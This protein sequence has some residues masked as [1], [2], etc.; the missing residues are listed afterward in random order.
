MVHKFSNSKIHAISAAVPKNILTTET[1]KSKFQSADVERISNT[2][3][4][5]SFRRLP[6]NLSFLD[7]A[8][9]ACD[10]IFLNSNVAKNQ[11]QCMI[12]VTNTPDYGIPQVGLR[13]HNH[14]QLDSSVPCFDLNMGCS[15]FIFGLFQAQMMI[16]AGIY[17][18]ILLVVGETQSKNIDPNDRSTQLIFGDAATAI[19]VSKNENTNSFFNL[20]NSGVGFDSIILPNSGT[21]K[22]S[23]NSFLKINGGNLT[24]F[25]L[26]EAPSA[27][28]EL[29]KFAQMPI[30][31]INHFVLHQMNKLIIDRIISKLS[32]D[33]KK[34]IFNSEKI[35]N[36]G[37]ASIPLALCNEF[38]I[39]GKGSH[40]NQDLE[41]VLL[42]GFGA[43]LSWG[44]AIL[45]LRNT[46]FIS[47]TEI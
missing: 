27:I 38:G 17:S 1:L 8:C 37:S 45:D 33:S 6:F 43:G 25:V 3:G 29:L 36:T 10:T 19:I 34:S 21:N 14:L 15:G 24:H 41:K 42:C 5:E 46:K 20:K 22:T 47:P 11:I 2:T 16:S 4:F 44:C 9:A 35:G 23:D 39:A 7:L 18:H 32:I 28:D 40:Q 31:S 30:A 13:I 26:S 12:V